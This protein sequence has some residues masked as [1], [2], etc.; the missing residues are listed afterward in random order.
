MAKLLREH[1]LV[2]SV[3]LKAYAK[4][5][6]ESILCLNLLSDG[7]EFKK[8]YSKAEEVRVEIE[9]MILLI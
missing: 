3:S 7:D 8:S 2:K 4:L 5:L 9:R 1:G 6:N